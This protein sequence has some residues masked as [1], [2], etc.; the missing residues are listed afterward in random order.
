MPVIKTSEWPL[1]P[2]AESRFLRTGPVRLP[3]F[4]RRFQKPHDGY[5]LVVPQGKLSPDLWKLWVTSC[6]RAAAFDVERKAW[7]WS[8]LALERES[9]PNEASAPT[10]FSLT[11]N[12]RE[13]LRQARKLA[14]VEFQNQLTELSK[15]ENIPEHLWPTYQYPNHYTTTCPPTTP[16]PTALQRI[17]VSRYW[18]KPY[19]LIAA[20]VGTG[21]SRMVVDILTARATATP[22]STKDSARIILIVAPLALH[23]NWKREFVK[24]GP[25][26]HS[27]AGRAT[28]GVVDWRVHKFAPNLGFW[29]DA[30]DS[31]TVLFDGAKLV[32]GGL[33]IICTP[34]ALSRPTI[35]QQ[36]AEM[37]YIPTAIIVD[38]VQRF[39]RKTDNKAYK[40]LLTF[41]RKAH[42]FIGLSGTPTSKFEDW[43][44]LEELMSN[45]DPAAHWQGATFT[46]YQK[47]GD[48]STFTSSGLHQ[49]GWSFERGIKEYHAD[50][51]RK[52]HIFVADKWFYM[53]DALPGLD[54][55]E[56]GEFADARASFHQLFADY[57]DWVNAAA[58]LQATHGKGGKF[59]SDYAIA[60]TL[61]LRMRQLA[62]M[63]QNNEVLLK[64]WVDEFL[65]PAEPGVVWVEFVNDPAKQLDA[66]VDFLNTYGPT[67]YIAGGM[68]P[69]MRQEAIDGFQSGKYRFIVC[70]IDAGGVGLTLTRACKALFLTIPL[71]YQAVCQAIGRLHRIGQDKDVTSYFAMTSPVA[72]FAR[73]LYDKRCELNETIPQQISGLLPNITVDAPLEP[74]L[75]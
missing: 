54:Q 1:D 43:W 37:G 73:Y 22:S 25:Q 32:D 57:P 45:S 10:I 55:E 51:I 42:M 20:S 15:N 72:A 18:D 11:P 41:R 56:L 28:R 31:A 26:N 12:E 70:Q 64:E 2:K 8:W 65:D 23:E 35:T 69:E 59:G 7:I 17:V 71:G 63:S 30:E 75:P 21:K 36:F 4:S 24:W 67:C 58:E 39:F 50:R 74:A 47:L 49:R 53:K 66:T 27:A 19:A 60:T 61:L 52:S 6:Q 48:R 16:A 9:Q 3:V 29:R 68:T 46:D 34:N 33:V 13:E 44:A 14:E 5:A 38:E 62:A 40:N